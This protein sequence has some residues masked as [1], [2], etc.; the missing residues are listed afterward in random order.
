MSVSKMCNTCHQEKDLNEFNS[1]KVKDSYGYF[2]QRKCKACQQDY[3]KAL[4]EEQRQ[5]K[6]ETACRYS[7]KNRKQLAAAV[8]VKFHNNPLY[9]RGHSLSAYLNKIVNGRW[10]YTENSIMFT[11]IGCSYKQFMKHLGPKPSAD[12]QIGHI[13]PKMQAL[14]ITEMDTLFHWSNLKWEHK[15]TNAKN[16]FLKTQGA[17]MMC[18]ILLKRD[19]YSQVDDRESV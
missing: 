7:K 8:M 13:C 2:K 19:W 11:I 6:R 3:N 16:S 1:C 5:N 18:K 9:N 14:T 17:E 4:T 12:Y 15:E 10:I